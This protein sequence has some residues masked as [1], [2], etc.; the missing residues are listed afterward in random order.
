M[1]RISPSDLFQEEAEG[2]D[3][4]SLA[5]RGVDELSQSVVL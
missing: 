2:R 4:G 1:M 5:A 3:M